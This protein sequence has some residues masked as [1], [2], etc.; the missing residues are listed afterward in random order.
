MMPLPD[1]DEARAN[2]T[3]DALLWALGRPGQ[4]RTLPNP[5]EVEIIHALIGRECRVHAADPRL[6]PLIV[7]A[8]AEV[9]EL[10][11]AD[12]VFL[13]ALADLSPLREIGQGSDLYPDDGATVILAVELGTGPALR[14]SGPGVDGAVELRVGGLPPGFWEERARIM[15]YPM[16][17][18]IF[19]LDGARIV[20][21]PRST[22]VE[23]L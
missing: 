22:D 16:G 20:G 7:R 12:H 11:S 17:F 23:A 14:L 4:V 10:S 15:R 18:E 21:V 13:G 3:Y 8:G 1:L 6:I 9:A 5:G 19:L 2:A